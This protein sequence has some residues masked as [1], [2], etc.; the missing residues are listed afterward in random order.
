MTDEAWIEQSIARLE[1]LEAQKAE[2]EASGQDVP[3]QLAE[4]IA[5]LYEAL[6][7]AA[8]DEADEAPAAAAPAPAPAPAAASPAAS[9]DPFAAPAPAAAPASDAPF[10]AA[11]PAS[12]APMGGGMADYDYDDDIKPSGGKGGLIALAAVVVLAAAG[13]GYWF[14]TQNKKPEAPPE[15]VGEAKVISASSV[16]EDTQE[17]QAAQGADADRTEGARYKEGSAAAKPSGKRPAGNGGGKR[18]PRKKKDD[19]RKVDLSD[20]RDPLAGI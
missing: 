12:A 10:A 17:P 5:T 13:G 16:P 19:G 18:K 14:M 6:E 15:P 4:E 11:A 1:T 7:S 20:S 2:L 8:G 3:A 9:D